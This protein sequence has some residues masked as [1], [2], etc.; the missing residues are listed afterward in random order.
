MLHQVTGLK[1]ECIPLTLLNLA[2]DETV[3]LKKV[4][5]LNFYRLQSLFYKPCPLF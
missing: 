1:Q 5:L 2:E 4:A 3:Y